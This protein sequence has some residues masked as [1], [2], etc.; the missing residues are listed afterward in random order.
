MSAHRWLTEVAR[1]LLSADGR[2]PRTVRTMLVRPGSLTLHWVEGRR[3]RFT[4]PLRLYLFTALVFFVVWPWTNPSGSMVLGTVSALVPAATE[5]EGISRHDAILLLSGRVMEWVP[6][7]LIVV[8]VPTFA[9]LS[10]T[11]LGG[12]PA[13]L[14]VHVV[15]SL[16]VH[17]VLF[18]LLLAYQPLRIVAW[19]DDWGL[20]LVALLFGG[21]VVA[22]ARRVF[23][24]GWSE[25][26]A[27]VTLLLILHLVL[28]WIAVIAVTEV[29]VSE[30]VRGMA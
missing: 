14:S 25:T 27:R 20:L 3:A 9:V 6:A 5:L 16:H 18:I 30:F 12:R 10:R 15:F 4:P 26:T 17:S 8:L 22:A 21:Y 28:F 23:A 29:V 24:R 7:L 11:I 1:D 2:I 19:V 13:Y